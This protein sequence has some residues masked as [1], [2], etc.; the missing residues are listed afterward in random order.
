[1]TET[2][3]RTKIKFHENEINRLSQL[4]PKSRD[5]QSL[6]GLGKNEIFKLR[7]R[8]IDSELTK[9]IEVEDKSHLFCGKIVV[10]TGEFPSF[11][12]RNE[13][14]KMLQSVGADVNTS[15]S[16]KTDYV[17]VGQKAGPKKLEAIEKF[18]IKTF[19]EHDFIKLF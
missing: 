1:M 16:Q 3:I 12:N 5:V 6:E 9:M 18:S 4:L 14:A 19:S 17:I 2:E 7:A 10:I 15:I 11:N 8:K 13:M